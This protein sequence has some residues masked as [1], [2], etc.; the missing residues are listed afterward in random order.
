MDRISSYLANPVCQTLPSSKIF[1]LVFCYRE[2]ILTLAIFLCDSIHRAMSR[3]QW[4]A[5]RMEGVLFISPKYV[6]RTCVWKDTNQ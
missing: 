3:A 2:H 1:S 4:F 6:F 5:N